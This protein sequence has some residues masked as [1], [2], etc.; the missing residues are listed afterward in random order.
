MHTKRRLMAAMVV[1][2]AAGP[3]LSAPAMA[4]QGGADTSSDGLPYIESEDLRAKRQ[5]EGMRDAGERAC[6]QAVD[7]AALL[8]EQLYD[9]K[10]DLSRTLVQV[11]GD[12]TRGMAQTMDRLSRHLHDMAER[13]APPSGE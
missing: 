7:T 10:L 2:L 12:V 11:S 9:L 1:G 13:M 3:M 6:R 4:Q 8:G 5:L